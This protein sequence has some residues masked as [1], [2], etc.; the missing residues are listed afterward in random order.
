[1]LYDYTGQP[2]K[3]K[4]KYK[5]AIEIYDNRLAKSNKNKQANKYNRAHALLLNGNKI[6]GQK[7]VKELLKNKPDDFIIQLLVDFDKDKHL[8]NYF[9]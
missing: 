9:K 1:M 6:K 2:V 8:S 3:A 5:K 7:E 4:E